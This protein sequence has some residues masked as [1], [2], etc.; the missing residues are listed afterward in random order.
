[1]QHQ[2]ATTPQFGPLPITI[3]LPSHFIVHRSPIPP[4]NT[5]PQF[6]YYA[7]NEYPSLPH[8]IQ[9]IKLHQYRANHKPATANH[10]PHTWKMDRCTQKKNTNYNK[11]H[12]WIC[13]TN[14]CCTSTPLPHS[15]N[16]KSRGFPIRQTPKTK[17]KKK[18]KK[19]PSTTT[20]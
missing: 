12:Q 17:G 18:V 15:T 4:T 19:N 14:L 11:I 10:S 7:K 8:P 5:T 2:H 6:T 3:H 13:H 9:W 16:K 20:T 1:M